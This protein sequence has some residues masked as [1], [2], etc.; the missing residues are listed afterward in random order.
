MQQFID[1]NA[2]NQ[3][4]TKSSQVQFKPIEEPVQIQKSVKSEKSVKSNTK[5]YNN[6]TPEQIKQEI[7]KKVESMTVDEITVQLLKD[8]KLALSAEEKQYKKQQEKLYLIKKGARIEKQKFMNFKELKDLRKKEHIE[9]ETR[10]KQLRE[11]GMIVIGKNGKSH[12][13]QQGILLNDRDITTKK[14]N[15]KI[16]ERAKQFSD[17]RGEQYKNEGYAGAM[18][19]GVVNIKN[20]IKKIGKK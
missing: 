17:R 5:L 9:K 8:N 7:I 15:S 18:K 4:V 20:L 13:L 19:D 11:D 3:F 1:Q 10:D 2:F 14:I 12:V 6:K 16:T